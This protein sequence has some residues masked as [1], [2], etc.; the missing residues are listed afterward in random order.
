MSGGLVFETLVF[1]AEAREFA[2]T[3][4]SPNGTHGS[5]KIKWDKIDGQE[6]I[7]HIGYVPN[8]ANKHGKIGSGVTIVNGFDLGQQTPADIKRL[9]I[10]RS[11]KEKLYP[12]CQKQGASAVMALNQNRQQALTRAL[13]LQ[14]MGN[15]NP[16]GRLDLVQKGHAV[17]VIGRKTGPTREVRAGEKPTQFIA[18]EDGIHG[19]RLSH[20]EAVQLMAAVRKSYETRLVSHFD[21]VKPKLPFAQLDPEIQTALMS[22]AY[23]TGSIWSPG[24]KAHGVF[25]AATKADWADFLDSLR[26]VEC[27]SAPE[28]KRR[29]EEASWIEKI[30]AGSPKT[31]GPKE[32]RLMDIKPRTA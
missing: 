25:V 10:D 8:I 18:P 11:L 20:H 6:G 12:F 15:D 16:W 2:M 5:T 3:Q 4:H 27:N 9:D 13:A 32:Q 30:T 24:H 29:L 22:L 21:N 17:G 26:S 19:L 28:R 31:M 7:W 23:N 1:D 14:A